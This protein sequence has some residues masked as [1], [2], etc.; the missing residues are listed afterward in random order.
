MNIELGDFIH[1][2]TCSALLEQDDGMLKIHVCRDPC[3]SIFIISD[4]T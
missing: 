2:T 4:E 3:T 1:T